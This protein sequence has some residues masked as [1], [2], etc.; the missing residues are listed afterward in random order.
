[1]VRNKLHKRRRKFHPRP[2]T[3][4]SRRESTRKTPGTT[5]KF[6]NRSKA[7][8]ALKMNNGRAHRRRVPP[9]KLQPAGTASKQRAEE[10]LQRVTYGFAKI[11]L[12]TGP[13]ADKR[14]GREL[15]QIRPGSIEWRTKQE[16]KAISLF[17]PSESEMDSLEKYVNLCVLTT[18]SSLAFLH[19]L[20]FNRAIKGEANMQKWR[21][22]LDRNCGHYFKGNHQCTCPDKNC[23][24]GGANGLRCKHIFVKLM[25]A[26]MTA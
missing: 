9:L 7:K 5:L 11:S 18:I 17:N 6:R 12:T 22:D 10:S 24:K 8:G 13:G 14:N 25:E 20:T 26:Y 19:N 23:R 3:M 4:H 2:K 15:N 21:V 16:Q 1:M